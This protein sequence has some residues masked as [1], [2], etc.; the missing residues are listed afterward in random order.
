V[1]RGH[2]A[3]VYS[4]AVSFDCEWVASGSCDE[5]VCVWSLEKQRLHRKLT[6]HTNFVQV[7][8]FIGSVL[9][10]GSSDQK[11]I[12]W[13]FETG[14]QISSLTAADEVNCLDI[15]EDK[16]LITAGLCS[17]K[18]QVWKKK[19]FKLNFLAIQTMYVLFG[20]RIEIRELF[21]LHVMKQ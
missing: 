3:R 16:T 4:V 7:V 8:L 12:E 5:S 15:S 13:N 18:I 17:G 10:S 9:L 2:T 14:E 11:V 20:S 6:G 21:R 19:L 1:L